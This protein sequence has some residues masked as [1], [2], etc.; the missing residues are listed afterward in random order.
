[1]KPNFTLE[2]YVHR[3]RVIQILCG[4]KELLFS[5]ISIAKNYPKE[6]LFVLPEL[7]FNTSQ[8]L[9]DFFE[10]SKYKK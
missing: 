4:Q 2:I 8:K 5:E 9:P 7:F 6:A 1:L 10:N 3:T